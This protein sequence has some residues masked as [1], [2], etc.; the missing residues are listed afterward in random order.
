MGDIMRKMQSALTTHTSIGGGTSTAA[1]GPMSLS[2]T[3][4]T[5]SLLFIS[6]TSLVVVVGTKVALSLMKSIKHKIK[7]TSLPLPMSKTGFF[8]TILSLSGNDLPWF[9]LN[10]KKELNNASTFQLHPLLNIIFGC[11][12]VAVVGE[13]KLSRDILN[14]KTSYKPEEFYEPLDDINQ[15]NRSVFTTNGDYWHKRRKGLAM[16]FSSKHV[17]RMNQVVSD[18][19]NEWVTTTLQSYIQNDESFDVTVEMIDVSLSA[20]SETA[21]E[22]K[23]SSEEKKNYVHNL[24]VAIKEFAFR[25]PCNPLRKP[26]GLLLPERRE[27][28]IASKSIRKLCMNVIKNYRQLENPIKDTIID[29]IMKNEAYANDSERVSDIHVLIVA[30]HETT[31]S[32]IAWIL[33]ELAKNPIEQQKL[34]DALSECDQM[35][36]DENGNVHVPKEQ[37]WKQSD[38]LKKVIKEGM[39][40]HPVA[41]SGAV[42]TIGKEF[43]TEN[44][45]V[46]PKGSLAFIPFILPL[47]DAVIYPNPD[48]F[49]PSRWDEPTDIMNEAFF[50][51]ALGAQNCVGQSLANVLIHST[52]SSI[53]AEFELDIVNEGDTHHSLILQPVKTLLKAKKRKM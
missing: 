52:I 23:I 13:P 17:Q 37:K 36:K 32:T 22:Y 19:L 28:H 10:I 44:G 7:G 21:F 26:F 33:K 18:K 46:L 45:H 5:N 40:L 8:N 41:A 27:A 49:I 20:I 43:K 50:P 39:R 48:L 2:A 53:C 24:H 12:M 38:V 14:D 11:P 42:R 29:R 9:L 25:A 4:N 15:G 3:I 16:A 35:S 34:Y 1:A 6:A 47:R 30:G 31:A 51:Y